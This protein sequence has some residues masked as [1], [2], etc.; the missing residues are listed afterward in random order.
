[1]EHLGEIEKR[2]WSS[3]DNL[4]ANSNFASNEYFLPVM[5]LIFL[6]HA[7]SRF[8]KVKAE[9]EPSLPRRGGRPRALTKEEFS[10]KGAIFLQPEAQFDHLVSLPDSADRAQVM[11]DAMETIENDYETLRGALPKAEY[12]ELDNGV[13]SD[14]LRTFNDP[15]LRRADGDVFGRIYEY[16][17]TQFADQKAHDGGEFFTPVALVQTIVNVI[18]PDHGRV[19]DPACRSG[20]CSCRARISSNACTSTRPN[21]RRSSAWRRT[22]RRSASPT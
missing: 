15:A 13:L 14:L 3:A 16:F 2:L 17:L 18:E 19:F 20:G 6:R 7:C 8:L 22:R 1:M 10:R 12:Q 11:I 4:R 21:G 9:I 5:G